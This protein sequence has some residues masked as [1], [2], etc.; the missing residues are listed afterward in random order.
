MVNMNTIQAQKIKELVEN[1][2]LEHTFLVK[3]D[4]EEIEDKEFHERRK[5]F[6]QEYSEFEQY[7]H[8]LE[9]DALQD[10]VFIGN[11]LD[12]PYDV[13]QK[14]AVG[15]L[16]CKEAKTSIC[17]FSRCLPNAY[18]LILRNNDIVQILL[19]KSKYV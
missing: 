8:N 4:F 14:G 6:I 17:D 18:N 11:S 12:Y 3:S 1:Y 2:G 13:P 7:V 5:R 19:T 15:K 16:M 10:V 9:E